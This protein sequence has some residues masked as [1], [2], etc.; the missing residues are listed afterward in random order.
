VA[1]LYLFLNRFKRINDPLNHEVGNYFLMAASQN[2]KALIRDSD[3]LAR[4]DG[5]KF[6]VELRDAS[7]RQDSD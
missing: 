2:M 3:T 6:V 4:T 7:T 5:G 1:V